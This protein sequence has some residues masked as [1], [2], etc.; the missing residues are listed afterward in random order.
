MLRELLSNLALKAPEVLAN[1][2][3]SAV[4]RRLDGPVQ[5][6]R[7][8]HVRAREIV[9]LLRRSQE[10]SDWMLLP[11][12]AGRGAFLAATR[13][14]LREQPIEWVVVGMGSTNKRSYI[15]QAFVRQGTVNS[16][17]LPVSVQA[18]IRAHVE[19]TPGAEIINIHNHP[20]GLPRDIK[21]L[22][23][24]KAPITSDSDRRAQQA[25]A[26]IAQAAAKKTLSP[27]TVR[28]Y[29]V[30]NS[31]IHQYWLP[32]QSPLRD[33]LDCFLRIVLGVA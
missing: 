33:D 12:S 24:G 21:N 19:M 16:V 2:V 7:A 26:E 3:A 6:R 10:R 9:P 32:T 1:K 14:L 30:E 11:G 15:K 31:Q 27:R 25:H 17:G 5:F 4:E 28:F 23:L 18:Q 13:L 20:N 29:V 22:L 8:D